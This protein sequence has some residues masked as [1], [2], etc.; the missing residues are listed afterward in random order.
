MKFD[1]ASKKSQG[2]Y[3]ELLG[4]NKGPKNEI[5]IE[6]LYVI[7]DQ[8]FEPYSEEQL[9]I[10]AQD[11]KTNGLLAPLVVAKVSDTHY[12]ILAGRNRY[13]ACKLLGME[14]VPCVIKENLTADERNLILL[15]SNLV[16]RQGLSIQERAKAIELKYETCRNLGINNNF[17]HNDYKYITIAK[18]NSQLIQLADKGELTFTTLYEL[19]KTSSGM[20]EELALAW[21]NGVPKLTSKLIADIRNADEEDITY[22]EMVKK[23]L[24]E[25]ITQKED[26][27]K[28][29]INDQCWLL[30]ETLKNIDI[31]KSNKHDV[32][33]ELYKAGCRIKKVK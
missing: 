22:E 1:F 10:L 27:E 6:K 16:Q 7:T 18:I 13:T 2:Y 31:N 8:P 23:S 14:S 33:M 12:D 11:I 20:Q 21:Q 3:D 26:K 5:N 15:N 4:D 24:E 17:T 29:E 9:N 25:K 19:S 30:Y 28:H 32:A